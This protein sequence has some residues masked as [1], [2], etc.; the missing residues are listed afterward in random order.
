MLGLK[1]SDLSTRGPLPVRQRD[2]MRSAAAFAA[3]VRYFQRRE[4]L[5][6]CALLA[7]YG[8]LVLALGLGR[9]HLGYGVETDFVGGYV[10]EAQRFLDSEPLLSEFFI[11]LCTHW[12]SPG[13]ASSSAIGS[14]PAW[15]FRSSRV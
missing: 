9:S 8:G 12:R 15:C 1:Q 7:A 10:P 11:P 5:F 2:A 4:R 13:C 6:L 14:W 3:L